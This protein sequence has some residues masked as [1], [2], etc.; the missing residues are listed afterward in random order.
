M[1]QWKESLEL[2]DWKK[3]HR[4]IYQSKQM[5]ARR[6]PDI[7]KYR[8]DFKAFQESYKEKKKDF[9]DN[10]ITEQELINWL[11]SQR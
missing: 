6:Y 1:E 10:K 4:Q 3:I 9:M 5:K 11:E 2:Y 7:D 8:R